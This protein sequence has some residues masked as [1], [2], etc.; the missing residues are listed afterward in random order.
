[1][2]NFLTLLAC[3]GPAALSLSGGVWDWWPSR[4]LARIFRLPP[5]ALGPVV[6]PPWAAFGLGCALWAA[7]AGALTLRRF[8]RG[9][10]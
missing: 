4:L 2:Q 10:L 1:M 8:S 6:L 7:A 3:Y 9:R 5:V